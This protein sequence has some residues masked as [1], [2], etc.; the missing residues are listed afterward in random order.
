MRM[1]L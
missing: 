1:W